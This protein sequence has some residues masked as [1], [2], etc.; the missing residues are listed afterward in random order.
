MIYIYHSLYS[1]IGEIYLMAG[2]GRTFSP[3][4]F[5]IPYS[6]YMTLWE[7]QASE[8][9]NTANSIKFEEN[10]ISLH[11]LI[12]NKILRTTNMRPCVWYCWYLILFKSVLVSS[13]SSP[14]RPTRTASLQPSRT[15]SRRTLSRTPLNV[16]RTAIWKVNWIPTLIVEYFTMCLVR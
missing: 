8:T 11:I 10:T 16:R 15:L 9:K 14:W 6:R 5:V 3:F 7:E 2:G 12:V 13:W 4:L 1:C